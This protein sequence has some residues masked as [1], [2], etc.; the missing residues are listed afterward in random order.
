[1]ILSNY[2]LI[3]NS[4]KSLFNQ[5]IFHSQKIK[6]KKKQEKLF[7]LIHPKKTGFTVHPSII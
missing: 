6:H 7:L 4:N 3:L 5:I 1:M 2:L